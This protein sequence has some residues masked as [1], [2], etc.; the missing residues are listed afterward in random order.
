MQ[1]TAGPSEKLTYEVRL[2]SWV[3]EAVAKR[4]PH[5]ALGLNLG[6]ASSTCLLR[7][8]ELQLVSTELQLKPVVV[9]SVLDAAV[10]TD[11]SIEARALRI[12]LD[13]GY[14]TTRSGLMYGAVFLCYGIG[15]G[16]ADA[17]AWIAPVEDPLAK[18][19]AKRIARTVGKSALVVDVQN[20]T[21]QVIV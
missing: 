14:S 16:H 9:G 7:L 19:M 10:V 21:L 20:S 18:T 12:C 6:P 2:E 13:S 3:C 17:L 1:V 8:E 4:F 5:W 15:G 11:H